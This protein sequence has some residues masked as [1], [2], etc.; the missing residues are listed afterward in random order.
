LLAGARPDHD[1]TFVAVHVAE[2]DHPDPFELTKDTPCGAV[3]AFE[4]IDGRCLL[5]S[6]Y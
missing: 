5:L 3:L 4:V 1:L 2:T 6:S